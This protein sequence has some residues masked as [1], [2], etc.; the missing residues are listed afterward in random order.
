MV[1]LD[2][3]DKIFVPPVHPVFG[4]VD[5]S[6]IGGGEAC[7]IGGSRRVGEQEAA[8]RRIGL[9]RI[10]EGVKGIFCRTPTPPIDYRF[11]PTARRPSPQGGGWELMQL[12]CRPACTSHTTRALL[13]PKIR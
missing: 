13:A 6:A 8:A 5:G 4:Q 3:G 2:E 7:K 9:Q 1:G 12:A 10:G 11:A